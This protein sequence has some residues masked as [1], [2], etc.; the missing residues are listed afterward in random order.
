MSPSGTGSRTGT[1][2]RAFH[3]KKLVWGWAVGTSQSP[4]VTA[5]PQ[6]S[7]IGLVSRGVGVNK[8]LVARA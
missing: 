8:R 2:L 5:L 7:G 1:A 3:K 6:W 4:I